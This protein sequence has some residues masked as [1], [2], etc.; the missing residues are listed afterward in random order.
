M[1]PSILT[2]AVVAA[3]LPSLPLSAAAHADT[4][5]PAAAARAKKKN[6]PKPPDP[7]YSVS[8]TITVTSIVKTRCTGLGDKGEITETV[9]TIM[10][11]SFSGSGVPGGK[12]SLKT[13]T[14]RR[15]VHDKQVVD[16]EYAKPMHVEGAW[17]SSSSGA[18]FGKVV[19]LSRG[20][21]VVDL[22]PAIGERR[23][24]STL[25]P[26]PGASAP[27][28]F[29]GPPARYD[30]EN[31]GNGCIEKYTTTEVSGTLDVADRR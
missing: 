22:K 31:P 24:S 10:E 30:E 7:T 16:V 29:G 21:L 18:T 23:R 5:A 28:R 19:F 3:L 8:G 26:A 14:R 27:V 17:L 2:S 13:R 20:L 25:R 11:H 12:G 15:A 4:P 6:P 9:T 1:R